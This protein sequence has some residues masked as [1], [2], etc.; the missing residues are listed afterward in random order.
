VGFCGTSLVTWS[1]LWVPKV[2]GRRV[3]TGRDRILFFV[4]FFVLRRQSL[5]MR[6]IDETWWNCWN[7]GTTRP[8]FS[9][10]QADHNFW[11]SGSSCSRILADGS[12]TF[13]GPW[14]D[15]K[16][17]KTFVV[18]KADPCWIWLCQHDRASCHCQ[19]CHHVVELLQ[20]AES[21]EILRVHQHH[22]LQNDSEWLLSE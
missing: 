20:N 12:T 15:A 7:Q 5:F 21:Q 11:T 1:T 18:L 10:R 19:G 2:A 6:K 14:M 16:D 4:L 22:Q 9:S 17:P 13:N 3:K 8:F